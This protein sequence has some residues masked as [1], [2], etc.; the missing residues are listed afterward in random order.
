MPSSPLVLL[1][2]IATVLVASAH[3]YPWDPD[4]ILTRH[5]A[6]KSPYYP[7]QDITEHAPP[8]ATCVPVHFNLMNRHGNRNPG[9]DDILEHQRIQRTASQLG[10]SIR[11]EWMRT[12]VSP[13]PY[14]D[15]GKLVK[16]GAE[17]LYQAAKR[18]SKAYPEIF[19]TPYN[20]DVFFMRATQEQRYGDVSF[21]ARFVVV[22]SQ[23]WP[24]LSQS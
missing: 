12:F 20:S 3:S 19:Q 9:D 11:F 16:K 22:Q 10:G 17:E 7:L 4:F 18:Y 23:M 8:P 6:S 1:F 21:F 15:E 14:E 5:L 24:E 2:F 13:V